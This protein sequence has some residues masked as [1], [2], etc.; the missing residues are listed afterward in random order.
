MLS[1]S[2][3]PFVMATQH[4]V[5]IAALTVATLLANRIGKRAQASPESGMFWLFVTGL[6]C[7]RLGFVIAYW[8]TYQSAPAQALDIR[9]GGF[10]AWAG[11]AG[12]LIVGVLWSWRRPL[13]RRALGWGGASGV[14]FWLIATFAVG[15]LNANTPLPTLKFQDLHGKPV[16]L[17]DFRGRP[18]VVNLWASWC[19]PCRREMPVLQAAERQRE[20]VTFLFVN[21]AETADTITRYLAAEGL[22]LH[23]LLLDS[24]GA[25]G[26]AV[27]SAALPTTLFYDPQG[28]LLNNHLG[29][30]SDASLAR[31]LDVF[32]S[33][34]PA[35]RN[36]P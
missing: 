24:Q 19:P 7:A 31:A 20:D 5:L 29:E 2:I 22:T 8:P 9:D 4:L 11:I 6:L 26:T 18:L 33:V 13:L 17:A 23:N 35:T 27:G 10:V 14:G 3:G 1:F 25:L 36:A 16:A 32:D 30:L 34:A 15:L 28:R 12:A 21:Q